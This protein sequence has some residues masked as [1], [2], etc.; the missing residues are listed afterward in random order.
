MSTWA[1]PAL[2]RQRKP[3]SQWRRATDSRYLHVS[4]IL[5]AWRQ[6]TPE[7]DLLIRE[8]RA[9]GNSW[10]DIGAKVGRT[11]GGV[12]SRHQRLVQI[13]NS[14]YV[15]IPN[16]GYSPEEEARIRELAATGCSI[17]GIGRTVGRSYSS[18]ERKLAF[19]PEGP[20]TKT[21]PAP[22]VRWS[23]T[24]DKKMLG[25]RAKGCTWR[26]IEKTL[27][28][29]S[30]P[31]IRGRFYTRR[32]CGL[33]MHSPSVIQQPWSEADCASLL[34]MRN[35]EKLDWKQVASRLERGIPSVAAKYTWLC[36]KL[37]TARVS[38][39]SLWTPA[40]DAVVL[41]G[42][43]AGKNLVEIAA[44]MGKS[45]MAVQCRWYKTLSPQAQRTSRR[46]LNTAQERTSS[47]SRGA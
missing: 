23:E 41:D 2:A 14:S 32:K 6:Y 38:V 42:R 4:I 28:D 45:L 46:D 16:R 18:I 35:V 47:S 19:L 39:G 13:D 10:S 12:L 34:H 11:R 25:M 26:E 3:W 37:G 21:K 20:S 22:V 29:R 43:A 17:H 9:E 27:P 40:E 24:E 7:Q 44:L 30:I 1:A 31:S 33:V 15:P 36:V 5:Q 8:M